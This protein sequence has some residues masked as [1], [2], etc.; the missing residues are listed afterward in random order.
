MLIQ[1][2]DAWPEQAAAYH[3]MRVWEE[4]GSSAL[5]FDASSVN[6]DELGWL[7]EVGPLLKRLWEKLEANATYRSFG[8]DPVRH[9]SPD[10]IVLK[11][12]SA[13]AGKEGCAG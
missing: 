6:R 5:D 11:V 10:S 12:E 2:L 4:R 3:R 1:H 7:V 9:P 8:D 13:K